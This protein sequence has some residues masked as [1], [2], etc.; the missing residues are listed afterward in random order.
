[1]KN[2]GM[3]EDIIAISLVTQIWNWSFV[4][5]KKLRSIQGAN[6]LK[7]TKIVQYFACQKFVEMDPKDRS[8]E[9]KFRGYCFHWLIPG[10]SKD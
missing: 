8:Q 6:G 10:A 7:G 9:L 3:L 4:L 5:V 1:M 2:K